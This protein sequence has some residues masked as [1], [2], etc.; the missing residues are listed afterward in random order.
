MHGRP[1]IFIPGEGKNFP[2]GGQK[3]TFCLKNNEKITFFVR[4][5]GGA[6]AP[7]DLPCVLPCK[8]ASFAFTGDKN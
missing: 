5:G 3:P 2:R 6:R 1:Q 8:H 7:L 4:P